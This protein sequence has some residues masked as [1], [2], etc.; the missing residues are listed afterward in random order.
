MKLGII[1]RSDNTGL[2]NQ[3]LELT[4]MLSPD[5]ILLIDS[6]PF[7]GNPQFPKRYSG[8]NVMPV[9]GFP[10]DQQVINFLEGL[11]VVISCEIFY[12]DN[13]IKHA[14]RH[15]VK[16]ILQYN[17]EFLETG[18]TDLPDIL[19]APS[20]WNIDKVIAEYGHKSRV[21]HLPPPTRPELFSSAR[22]ENAKNHRRI[23]HV[24]G[25]IAH[26]DR[27]GTEDVIEML[28]YSKADYE[29][30]VTTQTKFSK[31]VNDPRLIVKRD[32]TENREDLFSGYDAI[33]LPRRYAGLC[34]PMNEALMSGIPVFMTDISPNNDIL[35]DKWLVN[36]TMVETT[37]AKRRIEVYHVGLKALA[38][39]I[40]WYMGLQDKSAEKA[41]AY[42][43]GSS[44]FSPEVLKDKY[45]D[46][47]H[48]LMD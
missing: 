1:A 2:G 41:E 16:T 29:L 35:P 27:N 18:M 6:A 12:N 44:R 23:L 7:N 28:K 20:T 47:I 46:L 8:Y 34:L 38:S 31:D 17:H 14:K 32:N 25:R 11:D 5:K 37:M 13:F 40:D 33:V 36:S 30:V 19:L 15:N 22:E 3:T 21:V 39:K 42:E 45:L 10:S 4:K 24:A 43:I 48:S 9:S 26:K